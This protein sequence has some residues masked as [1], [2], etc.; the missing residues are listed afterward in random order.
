MMRL[1]E[2]DIEKELKK[3]VGW[4]VKNDKLHKEFQ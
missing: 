1:S 4:N 3:L 2:S